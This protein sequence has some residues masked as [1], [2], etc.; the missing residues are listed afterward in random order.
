M[1]TGSDARAA[2]A[3]RSRMFEDAYRAGDA[4]RLVTSYFVGE[5]DQPTAF[6]P[7][8]APIRGRDGLIAMFSGM[9]AGVPNIRLETLDVVASDTVAHEVGRAHLTTTEGASNTG[10][11]T[12]C[13]INT[14]DGWRA[15]YDF[16]AEDGWTD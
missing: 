4:A 8:S 7:G 1:S 12:V 16:F 14:A 10:R 6:P 13:W 15:K 3:E 11:Y 2:I 5:A 9:I